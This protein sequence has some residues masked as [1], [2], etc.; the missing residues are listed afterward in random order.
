MLLRRR[1]M[2]K[3]E[4]NLNIVQD[5]SP[6][7]NKEAEKWD[8][9]AYFKAKFELGKSYKIIVDGNS[10]DGKFYCWL[11]TGKAPVVKFESN[12]NG[13]SERIFECMYDY[14]SIMIAIRELPD[15]ENYTIIS[16]YK[17]EVYEL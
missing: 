3:S 6:I 15:G 14:D 16:I 9:I 17:L 2:M 12:Q 10:G 7:I 13:E 11:N 8:H 4:K 5:F 1:M